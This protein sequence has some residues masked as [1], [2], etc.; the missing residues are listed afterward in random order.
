MFCHIVISEIK[1]ILCLLC[2]C[3]YIRKKKT[4]EFFTDGW[5]WVKLWSYL[6]C[7]L[8]PFHLTEGVAG[9]Y[10]NQGCSCGSRLRPRSICPSP[11]LFDAVAMA[12][13]SRNPSSSRPP[14][15]IGVR[16]LIEIP[17]LYARTGWVELFAARSFIHGS[18]L[19]CCLCSPGGIRIFER[20]KRSRVPFEKQDAAAALAMWAKS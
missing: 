13:A 11:P 8:V 5:N 18:F 15:L 16:T 3:I 1:Y 9:C 2:F 7:C 14:R 19:Y 17:S 12:T 10:S 20:S 4:E 6:K